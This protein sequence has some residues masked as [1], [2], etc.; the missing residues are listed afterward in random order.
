[1]PPFVELGE[2]RIEGGQLLA[3]RHHE[4]LGLPQLLLGGLALLERAA[5]ALEGPR[6]AL[7]LFLLGAQILHQQADDL[8][9]VGPQGPQVIENQGG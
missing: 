3:R 4:R 8:A 2:P 9:P 6:L 7:A 1:M 5:I